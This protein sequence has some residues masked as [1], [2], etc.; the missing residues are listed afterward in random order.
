MR[1]LIEEGQDDNSS[2]HYNK[3]WL[4]RFAKKELDT[5]Q[6]ARAS[7]LLKKFTGG[8]FIEMGCGIAPHC[9]M[10]S[11]IGESWGLDISAKLIPLLRKAYPEINYVI[12]NVNNTPFRDEYF[13]YVAMGELLEHLENP[14]ETLKEC[15][16]ILKKGGTLALS[17][18]LNDN[19]HCA[20][21]EHIWSYVHED[22]REM[23]SKFGDIE[24]YIL[25]ETNHVYIIGYCKKQ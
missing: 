1:R 4:P 9:L 14:E 16:R 17:T 25:E 12:G 23:L 18:P 10:A 11:K 19:G 24:T 5:T 2:E 8:K 21:V 15:F 3:I 6:P 7:C 13:N 20:P 22:I